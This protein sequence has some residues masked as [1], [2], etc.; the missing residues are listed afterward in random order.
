MYKVQSKQVQYYTSFQ[1]IRFKYLNIN[2][3]F[4]VISFVV[5]PQ[6]KQFDI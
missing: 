2:L 3:P 1:S 6:Y 5:L 4:S